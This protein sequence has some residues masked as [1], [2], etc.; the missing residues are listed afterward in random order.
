MD[1]AITKPAQGSSKKKVREMAPPVGEGSISYQTGVSDTLDTHS[2]AF[3]TYIFFF[4][5]PAI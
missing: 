2:E 4:F 1:G 5:L 3:L